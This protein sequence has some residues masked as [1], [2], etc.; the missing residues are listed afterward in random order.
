MPP[1]PDPGD[2]GES[3]TFP[4]VASVGTGRGLARLC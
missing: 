1:G 4:K 3:R 2:W